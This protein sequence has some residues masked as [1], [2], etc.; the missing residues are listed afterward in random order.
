M[1]QIIDRYWPIWVTD[2]TPGIAHNPASAG[3]ISREVITA[4]AKRGAAPLSAEIMVKPGLLSGPKATRHSNKGDAP[5]EQEWLSLPK[6]LRAPMA[7]LK[8]ERTAELIYR[9]KEV[10]GSLHLALDLGYKR[11]SNRRLINM[12]VS[13]YR[14]VLS[15]LLGRIA[16][17]VLTRVFR[18]LG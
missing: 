16:N 14:P 17:G 4:L 12:V 11:K 8:D 3:V 1:E 2:V 6:S 9:L 15:E 10:D 7:I 13:A 18:K 5:A